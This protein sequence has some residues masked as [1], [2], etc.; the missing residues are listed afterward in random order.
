MRVNAVTRRAAAWLLWWIALFWWWLL[1]SGDWNTIEL[2][3]AACGAALAA[4][5]AELAR[6]V[7]RLR[8]RIPLRDA[9]SVWTQPAMVLVDFCIV[10]GSLIG[11]A[12]RGR[13]VRGRFFVRPFRPERGRTPR[14]FGS[15]AWRTYVATI[16]PNAY[17]VE[18]DDDRR[19]VLMHD[20]VPFPKSEEPAPE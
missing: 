15:R 6:A 5:A 10:L 11:N 17:V 2:V 18:V 1:L 19:T 14:R 4:T 20:L 8:W 7:A 13:I 16:S 12:A 3:A 9:L